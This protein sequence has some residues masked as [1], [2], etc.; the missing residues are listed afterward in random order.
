MSDDL[1]TIWQEGTRIDLIPGDRFDRQA[2]LAMLG[3]APALQDLVK[4]LDSRSSF[5]SDLMQDVYNMLSQGA[6]VLRDER[7]VAPER[8]SLRNALAE[9][10]NAPAMEDVRALTVGD[11][12]NVMLS[13]AA[14]ED[15]LFAI[16]D[17]A[18]ELDQQREELEAARDLAAAA[19]GADAPGAAETL[20]DVLEAMSVL[21]ERATMS[22]EE[23]AEMRK[24]I[25][26]ALTAVEESDALSTG[27]G[28]DR[29]AL[30]VMD[31]QQRL[32]LAKR[33]SSP[34]LR[35]FINL[36]GRFKQV[37]RGEY[38]RRF[39]DGPDEMVGYTM[40]D[41][42]ARLST[43]EVIN[44]AIP[45]L[46]DDFWLRWTERALLVKEMRTSE[47]AGKGPILVVADES[48]TMDQDGREVW[49]KALALSMLDQACREGRDFTYIGFGG[50]FDDLREITFPG[51]RLDSDRMIEL[52][53]GFIN[54]AT[55]FDKPLRRALDLIQHADLVKPDVVFITDGQAPELRFLEEWKR[56]RAR[57]SVRCHAIFLGN[58]IAG[59]DRL[60]DLADTVRAISDITDVTAVA[61]VLRT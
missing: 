34:K 53:T 56:E 33:L 28:Y 22:T 3:R 26:A 18:V 15:Q 44:M 30:R 17:R 7:E 35:R 51:G 29:G 50:Q 5:A 39:A 21:E 41:D 10:L 27:F 43:Q 59:R 14:M 58:T 11:D 20:G 60:E 32:D 24:A 61:D 31:L 2:W 46:A 45:E 12:F 6:P 25:V 55:D 47:H 40:G 8:M 37:A 1:E 16:L 9:A 23:G 38:R 52:A 42:L 13:I 48:Q 54:G 19:L 4:R 57:L 49:A 36:L